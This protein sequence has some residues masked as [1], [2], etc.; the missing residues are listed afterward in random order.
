[1]QQ[2][3]ARC[4][5]SLH[6]DRQS[7]SS[8]CRVS[9]RSCRA[10]RASTLSALASSAAS[11]CIVAPAPAMRPLGQRWRDHAKL[12]IRRHDANMTNAAT[13]SEDCSHG[14]P[15]ELTAIACRVARASGVSAMPVR[16]ARP[17]D[18]PTVRTVANAVAATRR[19]DHDSRPR[20]WTTWPRHRNAAGDPDSS[21]AGEDL[22]TRALEA[23]RTSPRRSGVSRTNADVPARVVHIRGIAP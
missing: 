4:R 3:A 7:L 8:Q 6:R 18:T 1:M 14:S 23:S 16:C 9:V 17:L 12:N 20:C 22:S 15:R 19:R 11:T 5:E 10:S 2:R 13:S 21:L